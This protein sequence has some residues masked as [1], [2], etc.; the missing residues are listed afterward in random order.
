MKQVPAPLAIPSLAAEFR[1]GTASAH[2]AQIVRATSRP[3]NARISLH[4]AGPESS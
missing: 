3:D 2:Q 1:L 4:R